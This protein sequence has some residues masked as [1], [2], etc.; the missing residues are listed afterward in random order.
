MKEGF[1]LRDCLVVPVFGRQAVQSAK[2]AAPIYLDP[3]K[4]LDDRVDDLIGRLT[5]AEKMSLLG[6]TAPAIDR[7]KVPAMNGWN[8]SLHGI[9]WTEPT[10]MFPVPISM[11][12]TWN[13]A[14]VRDIAAAI[15]DEGRAINNYWPTVRERS[16][17]P[18]VRDRT[19]RYRR[20]PAVAAQRA[21]LSFA[22]DQHQPR[23]AMGTNLGGLRRGPLADVENDGRL[24]EGDAGRR[25][26]VP[27]AGGH[28][29]A[30]RGQQRRTGPHEDRRHGQRTDAARVL[31]AA[32]QG[33]NRRGRGVVY[34]V[35]VQR[36]QRHTR[37]RA[38]VPAQDGAARRME[39]PGVHRPG[40]RRGRA[41]GDRPPEVRDVRGSGGEDGSGRQR[42]RQ[43]GVRPLPAGRG[44]EGPADRAPHRSGAPARVA[45]PVPARRVR[46]AGARAIQE[47]RQGAD[48]FAGASAAGAARGARVDR[49]APE[50]GWL[51]PARRGRSQD[52][53][54]DRAVCGFA[55]TGPNYTGL[56][57][58]FVK[59]LD[60][61]RKRV[62]ASTKVLYA[63]GSG[64]LE[65]DNPEASYAEA[66]AIARQADVCV[67]FVGINEILEREGIDRNF[68]NLPPVQSQL[69]RRVLEANP[70]TAIVL[71]NGGPCRWSAEAAR[72]ASGPTRRRCSTCSGR[73]RRAGPR[74]PR[75]CS[76]TTTPAA[77][78]HTP[79]I[80]RCRTS[81]R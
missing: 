62:G 74:S 75:C 46:S 4:P 37:R 18:A 44:G 30:L 1:W 81:R 73:A 2:Q 23:S 48:R 54:G 14:L 38:R 13:P 69:V 70:R 68:I 72:G 24:R 64:I 21:R 32:L 51:S 78:C 59:P 77:G 66:I 35:V 25:S 76:A 53:R 61:I 29:E 42:S 6:T 52:D 79:C 67:L 63:R 3:A 17:R 8:Q 31:P 80:N 49:A 39:V 43:L 22:G 60:G 56:Y 40:Q 16:N 9:V 58:T 41:P 7:L 45:R 71:Q 11:A 12:A 34:H 47:T 15:A 55:Q 26:D 10:T 36:D 19:S 33:G 20:R 65:S 57:S 50:S 28:A 5:L 27:E